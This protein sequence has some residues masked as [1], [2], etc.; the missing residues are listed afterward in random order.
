M[1][2]NGEQLN[3]LQRTVDWKQ[4]LAIAL[5]VPLLILPSLGYFASYVWAFSIVVWLL[6]VLQG[7][8]QNIAYGELA[9]MFPDVSGLPGYAQKVF[10]NKKKDNLLGSFIGGFSAWSYWFAWS[11][12][13]AIF[14]LL[15]G[16]YLK[17]MIPLFSNI[18]ELQ[19]SILA[20]LVIFILLFVVNLRG[21]ES[22]ALLSYILAVL[23]L[24]P[25][26]IITIAPIVKGQVNFGNVQNFWLPTDWTFDMHHILILIGLFAMAQWS[27][28][29][30][31]TAAIYGPEYKNPH[32]DI[33]KALFACGIICIFT[34]IGI[35]AVS[36]AGLGVDTIIDEPYLPMLLLAETVFG[37]VGT[38]VAVLALIATMILIIQTAFLGAA[39]AMHSMATE[40]NLPKVFGKTNKS[41]VPIVAMGIIVLLNLCLITL[42]TPSAIVA[43]S[44]IGYVFAN[45]ISLFA[46]AKT[47]FDTSFK[48]ANRYFKA[49]AI[50]QYL[51]I[52]FGFIN[53]PLFLVGIIYLNSIDLGWRSTI[54]GFIVLGLYTPLWLYSKKKDTSK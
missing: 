15:I 39:R 6:S 24:V 3:S 11:P 23:S 48:D 53:I 47:K 34:F 45:G 36:I 52:I 12:V 32:K 4:G 40:G 49:P 2:Q 35:Q 10:Q 5:G 9:T 50:W 8:V 33:I 20:G 27:A 31:E 28:C 54:I 30:W 18:S 14:S 17:E 21:L 22:G 13:M 19:I 7:F 25:I 29:A 1:N 51:T 16:S 46:Y 44:S 38:D 43:A 26:G 37:Q 41:G 42:G